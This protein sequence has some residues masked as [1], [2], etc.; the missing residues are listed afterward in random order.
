METPE[1]RITNSDRQRLGTMLD[2]AY[3]AAIEPRDQLHRLE[4]ELEH[5]LG[6]EEGDVPP[7]VVTMDSTVE[8]IDLE[9]G[10]PETYTLVY[11]EQ[12][13]ITRNQISVV[14]PV[15]RAIL[16]RS[17]G[18]VVAVVTPSGEWW[19]KIAAVRYQPERAKLQH[20]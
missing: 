16:G 1:I 2:R 6:V 7:Y 20:A 10:D 11:P 8:I 13:D 18:D 9:S 5:A 19:I 4:M 3:A 12:A 14:A 15:G 17:V